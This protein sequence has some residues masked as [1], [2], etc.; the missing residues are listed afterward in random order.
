MRV[1]TISGSPS[2]RS[3]TARLA[4]HVNAELRAEGIAASH[5]RIADLPPQALLSADLGE[6]ALARAVETVASADGVVIVTPIFK[7]SFSGLLK[8]FLDALPQ[9]ALRGKSVLPLATGGTL[10]HVLALDYALRP[11]LQSMDAYH[12]VKCYFLLDTWFG[13]H[14]TLLTNDRANLELPEVIAVFRRSLQLLTER[15]PAEAGG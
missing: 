1:V 3:R 14:E 5:I 4:E 10:A 11:V 12:V 15:Q 9:Y 13:G 8:V 6:P 7:A 2:E